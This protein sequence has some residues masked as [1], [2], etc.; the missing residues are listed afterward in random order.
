MAENKTPSLIELGVFC[1]MLKWI[2]IDK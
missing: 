2:A 1:M